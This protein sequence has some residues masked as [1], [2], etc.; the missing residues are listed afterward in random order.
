MILCYFALLQY[1]DTMVWL[2]FVVVD[3]FKSNPCRCMSL[4]AATFIVGTLCILGSSQQIVAVDLLCHLFYQYN[5]E[6]RVT[7]LV[8]FQGF[9]FFILN[10]N[11]KAMQSQGATELHLKL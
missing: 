8:W 2:E 11:C 10:V 6:I 3:Y 9:F 4:I 5:S 7:N 1:A